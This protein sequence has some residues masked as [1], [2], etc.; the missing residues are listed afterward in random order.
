MAILGKVAGTML[1][2]NL[3]R[4][5]TDLQIDTDLVY[6]DVLNRRVGIYNTSPANTLSVNGSFTTSNIYINIILNKNR[7]KY[8][9]N[10]IFS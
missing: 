8:F 1:K 4:N 10:I 7:L 6:F 5:G 2:D 9:S 3:L